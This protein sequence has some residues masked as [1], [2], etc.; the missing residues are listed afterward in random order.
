MTASS[1]LQDLAALGVMA[2]VE[3]GYLALVPASRVP[4]DLLEAVR[5]NKV[6]L[7]EMLAAPLP[8]PTSVATLE[9]LPL[10]LRALVRAASSG[11]LPKG[12]VSLGTGLT[13]D[14]ER[15][16]LGFAAQYLTGDQAH[17]I[18][19]LRDCSRAWRVMTRKA[20]SA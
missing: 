9:P 2:R 17:A 14:L 10:E 3:G 7:L 18:L 13:L 6:A 12:A 1:V 5:A 8:A 4:P 16:V 15:Y 19:E 11:T 20:V